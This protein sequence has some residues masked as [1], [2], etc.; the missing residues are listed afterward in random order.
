MAFLLRLVPILNNNFY[1]TIDQGRDAVYGRYITQ[2][3]LLL[4]GP[5][6]DIDGVY[7]GVFWYNLTAI[8]LLLTQGH[9]IG[10]VLMLIVF[11]CAIILG[12]MLVVKKQF[13]LVSAL[14]CGISLIVFL[15]FYETSRYAFNPF[16]LPALV[17]LFIFS[18]EMAFSQ[19]SKWFI[20]SGLITGL[21][22][23]S[24]IIALP[25]FIFTWIAM[26][27]LLLIKRKITWN[28]ILL[29]IAVFLV[30]ISPHIISEFTS[31]F[32]QINAFL[33]HSQSSK[34]IFSLY[35][36]SQLVKTGTAF[37]EIL[38][39][40]VLPQIPVISLILLVGLIGLIIKY[41][42][43]RFMIINLTSLLIFFTSFIWFSLNNG[44]RP[45]HLVY[46]PTMLFVILI[47][48]LL[49]FSKW[50]KQIVL[51][52]IILAQV[53]NLSARLKS[54]LINQ[55]DPG[56]LKNQIAAI[57]WI[58]QKNLNSSP[59]VYIYVPSVYDYHYQYLISW[60]GISKYGFVPCEYSTYP[61]TDGS[62][63]IPNKKAFLNPQKTCLNSRFLIIEPPIS[64]DLL[65]TWLDGVV[66]N[67]KLVEKTKIGKIR[68]EMRELD[69]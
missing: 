55:D 43:R 18:L 39:S 37:S 33:A 68:L 34:S 40:L 26:G 56:L 32:S 46:L 12:L 14:I 3:H 8:A 59:S 4:T 67:T 10:P 54:Y 2:G 22:L 7:H 44:L 29:S 23:H 41:Q 61:G 31:G 30:A 69:Y 9:P 16:L 52:F 35:L 45:W 65:N 13:S 15:P 60:H 24:E 53:I 17:L 20:L 28:N 64:Q 49:T 25:P 47:I 36:T 58:Y 11:N 19:N 5:K 21:V 66:K 63:Y 48:N 42:S 50:I 6:T 62:S 1:F 51:G 27:F 57:D 38:A